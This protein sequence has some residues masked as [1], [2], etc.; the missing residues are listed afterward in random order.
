MGC[1]QRKT[2]F[3]RQKNVYR[4]RYQDSTG[5]W[6]TIKNNKNL[7]FRWK[8]SAFKLI[9]FEM[10]S[11]FGLYVALSGMYR[12]I[13]CNINTVGAKK[14][15]ELFELVCI[16]AYSSQK[17]IPIAFLLGFYVKQIIG[18][19]WNTYQAL[20]RPDRFAIKLT[21]LV[22]GSVSYSFFKWLVA[23]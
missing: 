5:F 8:G 1:W 11:F 6:A 18:R 10:F 17:N 9:W 13:L 12:V 21:N 4:A 20:P 3:Q 19:W 2:T 23:I 7:F 16:E 22:P 15:R 14:L